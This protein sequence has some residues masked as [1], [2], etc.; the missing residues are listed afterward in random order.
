MQQQPG[1]GIPVT[2]R[3]CFAQQVSKQDQEGAGRALPRRA[4]RNSASP[5]AIG[6]VRRRAKSVD[7]PVVVAVDSTSTQDTE[8]GC[9]IG[10]EELENLARKVSELMTIAAEAAAPRMY[11]RG[12]E[13]TDT[14]DE[15]SDVHVDGGTL[16]R[17]VS[18]QTN[19]SRLSSHVLNTMLENCSRHISVIVDT[20]FN[21][22]AALFQ[23][24]EELKRLAAGGHEAVSELRSQL[25]DR[26]AECERIHK[27][28][29]DYRK[30][31][32]REFQELRQE[33]ASEKSKVSLASIENTK[34][35]QETMEVNARLTQ[36]LGE[37]AKLTREIAEQSS[38]M[39]QAAEEIERL[40]QE[41]RV[42]RCDQRFQMLKK[43]AD[44]ERGG[45]AM[46]ARS[47]RSSWQPVVRQMS[48]AT[49]QSTQKPH[50]GGLDLI[51]LHGAMTPSCAAIAPTPTPLRTPRREESADSMARCANASTWSPS[52][53]RYPTHVSRFPYSARS[54]DC[55]RTT[56]SFPR[57]FVP[58]P[59]PVMIPAGSR[60]EPRACVRC[61]TQPHKVVG[62]RSASPNGAPLVTGL[63]RYR[64]RW[65]LE[66]LDSATF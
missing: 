1:R 32:A 42:A 52:S 45:D 43:A 53:L 34:T 51:R 23:T 12:S 60:V 28:F 18:M 66:P 64:L 41:L 11:R 49:P 46:S 21:L 25:Q 22:R 39:A 7:G 47:A 44:V 26:Q 54:T 55:L 63:M 36:A 48:A 10:M 20:D 62:T 65:V 15:D 5:A 61:L 4:A 40:A 13:Q 31:A 27:E 56:P 6:G 16:S 59:P 2:P 38:W 14:W 9:D 33:L 58:P 35:S 19:R 29:A 3:P 30:H 37:N 24:E 57:C 8:D 17:S 50:E